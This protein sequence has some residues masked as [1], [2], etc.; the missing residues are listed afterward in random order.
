MNLMNH[1]TSHEMGLYIALA[2]LF[3]CA[4]AVRSMSRQNTMLRAA[5]RSYG[6]AGNSIRGDLDR[7]SYVLNEASGGLAQRASDLEQLR[8]R[9]AHQND[10]VA[11][12]IV[13]AQLTYLKTLAEAAGPHL[14]RNSR[15]WL[16]ER[17]TASVLV[18]RDRVV[19]KPATPASAQAPTGGTP[20]LAA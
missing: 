20:E 2:V 5:A 9:L 13:D 8:T 1:I 15:L 10:P 7:V 17:P 18:Q 16:I 6:L 11:L 14:G 4:I 12:S 3:A 19:A